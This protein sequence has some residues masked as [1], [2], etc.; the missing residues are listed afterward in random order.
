MTLSLVPAPARILA[1]EGSLEIGDG[2]HVVVESN[3]LTATARRFIDD[4][5]IDT[6]I[7]LELASPSDSGTPVVLAL[8]TAELDSV[9][10]AGG[11]RADGRSVADAADERHGISITPEGVRVWGATA[12]GV[13]RGLTSL[14]QLIAAASR[15][16]L[17]ALPA[18]EILD[19]PRFA[20]RGLSFDVARTFHGP[21]TVR[22]VIDM[23][24]LHKLN[25]LHLHLTDDQGWR[26][27]VPSR[28]ALTAIGGAG[29]LGDRPGGYYTLAEMAELVEYAAARF[30]TLVP[31]ID[32]PGHTGAI[33]RAY[34]ELAPADGRAGE[35]APG[36][37]IGT[38]DPE[39]P[40]TWA[41][42]EDVLD[43]VIPQFPQSAY[44]H[45]GGDEAF[46]MADEAHAAFVERAVALVRARGRRAL[47]WQETAR[48]AIG[49]DE[50]VQY[51]IDSRET[52]AMMDNEALKTMVPSELL[53]LIVETMA[54]AE[55]DVPRALATGAKLL[56]SPTSRL[57]FDRPHAEDSADPAQEE[58]RA[59]VGLP[60]YPPMSL[61]HGVEWDPVDDTPGV[62]SDD[63]IAGVEAAIWC[64][65]ITNRDEL[66][67]MLLPRIGGL[68]EKSWAR[69]AVTEW[70]DYAE[71]IAAQATI[72][73]ARGWT[74]FAANTVDWAADEV[75]AG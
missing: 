46:G 31:E 73:D 48:A 1:H 26:I 59:R 8:D 33:F 62:S 34:P 52:S 20:W 63:Q 72:W 19:G 51:W 25:V 15:D 47:G 21:E 66:E 35:V 9:A 65:T 74:W 56:I 67:F 12:E 38:L 30:V 23:C 11:V 10:A 41:F 71:R 28:P 17:A 13:H 36:L 69:R 43:A 6:G 16:R 24:S 68:A 22:R 5:R 14:R 57:Y 54:K 32:M 40:E 61:R 29:A 39:R 18:A 4:V 70:N 3:E 53:P 42:V 50:I 60:V 7:A 49:A 58:M 55:H 45:V 75:T 37:A 44:V 2:T 27:E 64:E